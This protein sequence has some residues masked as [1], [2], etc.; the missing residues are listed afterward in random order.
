MARF[1][2]AIPPGIFR[3]GTEYQAKGRFYDANLVRWYGKAVGPIL[4]WQSRSASPVVGKARAA[5]GWK[6]NSGLVWLAIGTHSNLFVCD[7]AGD[8]YDIT[9][10]G[11]TAGL[12]D[13]SGAGGFGAG[14]FGTGTFG[15]PRPTS[16][17]IQDATQWTLDTFGQYL[18]GV[19]P[20]DGKIYQWTLNIA[21]P[22]AQLT[23]SP[24]CSA[25]ICTAEEFIFAL[26]TTDPRTVSWS[27][28]ANGTTWAPSTTNQAGSFPLRT[29]GRL[30][31][32][33]LVKGGTLLFTDIDVHLATY[34]GGTFVYSFD[35]IGDSCGVV[36]RQ[37]AVP[38]DMQA[39]WMSPSG[40]WLYNGYVQRFPCDVWDYVQKNINWTQISK[41]MATHNS[42]FA[43]I[44]WRYCSAAST[45]IDSCVVWNYQTG[46]WNIGRPA[47]TCG[48]D[49][50]VFPNPIM[51]DANGVIYN[52]ETG[53]SYSGATP[54]ITS[55][56]IEL[57]N[58]DQAIDVQEIFPDDATVGDVTATFYA[59]MQHDDADVT[60]GP[61]T[62]TSHTDVRFSGRVVKVRFDGANATDWRVGTPQLDIAP[63]DS[64]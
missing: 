49:R 45:E 44:E 52:H 19:S 36:S 47:R 42:Q 12:P 10:V 20:N 64:R 38:F 3:N 43:E 18:V 29:E 14:T 50:G 32:G 15:T 40:F 53:Y 39:A 5:A 28:Q 57:G 63:G 4:G 25:L 23:N 31:C 59:K 7:L 46:A 55:G 33:E 24:T 51:V 9:P 56:P 17:Q 60:Y 37:A 27:D 61:Y 22:A 26:G 8:V 41:T 34:I 11:F 54:Y 62:L 58:G 6:D 30:M 2:L 16:A 13:A 48:I 1:P 21:T 35:K